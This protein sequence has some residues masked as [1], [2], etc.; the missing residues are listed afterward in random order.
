MGPRGDARV[1]ARRNIQ[2]MSTA[3]LLIAG[4][5]W[6]FVYDSNTPAFVGREN[7]RAVVIEIEASPGEGA[8]RTVAN[9]EFQFVEVRLP[10]GKVIPLKINTLNRR[11]LRVGEPIPM[12]QEFYDDDSTMY[13]IDYQEWKLSG[14]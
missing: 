5:I 11:P 8:N 3:L 2:T 10:D 13:V 7:V 1:M 4:G 14:F 6:F 12:I 9:T